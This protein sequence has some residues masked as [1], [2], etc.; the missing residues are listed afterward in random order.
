MT[1]R[2]IPAL[3]LGP[4]KKLIALGVVIT[5]AYSAICVGFLWDAG[6]RDHEQA[7][8]VAAT[9]THRWNSKMGLEGD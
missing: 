7:R 9:W 2:H 6:S 3:K 1:T 5:L 8:A 4:T